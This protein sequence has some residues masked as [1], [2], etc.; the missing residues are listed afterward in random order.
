MDLKI[1]NDKMSRSVEKINHVLSNFRFMVF[2]KH[3][4]VSSLIHLLSWFKHS[5]K[6]L[7]VVEFQLLSGSFSKFQ[8]YTK[9]LVFF[10]CDLA[11]L[12]RTCRHIV[13]CFSV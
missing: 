2:Q 12:L 9:K 8:Q 7:K 1:K 3:V 5:E 6:N 4:L 10:P 13:A 11:L